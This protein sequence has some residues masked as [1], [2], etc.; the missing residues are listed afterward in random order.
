MF[1]RDVGQTNVHV[2]A[3]V[4]NQVVGE[5]LWWGVG[6]CGMVDVQHLGVVD[7]SQRRLGAPV[8][9]PQPDRLIGEQIDKPRVDALHGQIRLLY[10]R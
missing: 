5:S 6:W 9:E 10:R 4:V 2:L 3:S 1:V 8:G 7:G